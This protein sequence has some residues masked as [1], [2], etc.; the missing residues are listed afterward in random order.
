MGVALGLV[1]EPG[2]N[3]QGNDAMAVDGAGRSDDGNEL[4]VHARSYSAFIK[5]AKWSAIAAVIIAIVVM[6]IISN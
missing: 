5:I 6:Y 3:D 2:I 1:M 4:Q